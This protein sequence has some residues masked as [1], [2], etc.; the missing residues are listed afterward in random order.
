[1]IRLD[2]DRRAEHAGQPRR[3]KAER[4]AGAFGGEPGAHHALVAG[5]QRR[6]HVAARCADLFRRRERRDRG[7]RAR[8]HADARLAQ[9]V[10]L[11]GVRERA[12]G[13][14]RSRRADRRKRRAQD[15][16]GAMTADVARKVFD[17]LAPRQAAAEQRHRDRVDQAR[18]GDRD[19]RRRNILVTQRR[20]ELRQRLGLT[21][22]RASH[23]TPPVRAAL[24]QLFAQHI[25]A[26]LQRL[27]AV[28]AGER[29]RRGR[30]RA[31]RWRAKRSRCSC[32]AAAALPS[33]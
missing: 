23:P 4:L 2:G 17:A 26:Q 28:V 14:R 11:E 9:I 32:R 18:L 33:P 30:R 7:G 22:H 5:D 20:R 3:M 27:A 16:A 15:R 8:M 6:D 29:F 19:H 21:R 25:L 10:E 31:P 1:M 12:V 13:K 24:S